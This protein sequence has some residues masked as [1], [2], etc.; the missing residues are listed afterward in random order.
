MYMLYLF[1]T[2]LLVLLL[3]LLL[4]YCMVCGVLLRW[5]GGDGM[6][7]AWCWRVQPRECIPIFVTDVIII[8]VFCRCDFETMVKTM[9]L[10]EDDTGG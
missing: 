7:K 9:I 4:L 8:V 5:C 10:H 2:S 3:L 1:C 6:C